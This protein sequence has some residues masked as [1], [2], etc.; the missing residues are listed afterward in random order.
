MGSWDSTRLWKRRTMEAIQIHVESHTMNLDCGVHL[1]PAWYPIIISSI[2]PPNFYACPPPSSKSLTYSL[3]CTFS[4][5]YHLTH[6]HLSSHHQPLY[7]Y[8]P[9]SVALQFTQ[10]KKV[11]EAEMFCLL[12]YMPRKLLIIPG[13]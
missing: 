1:S 11:P 4:V 7:L 8:M 3:I 2:R 9:H 5:I 12:T 6:Q 13:S 10:L